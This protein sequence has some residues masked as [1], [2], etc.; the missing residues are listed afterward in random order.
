MLGP[1]VIACFTIEIPH[2][3][4]EGTFP[5]LDY[6]KD[7]ATLTPLIMSGACYAGFL[8]FQ[9]CGLGGTCSNTT[10]ISPH[11]SSSSNSSNSTTLSPASKPP[12]C[13]CLPG[14]SGHSDFVPSDRT[15]W[16][17]AVIECSFNLVALRVLWGVAAVA[18]VVV[19]ISSGKSI[20]VQL[21]AKRARRLQRWV[22][23]FPLVFLAG[24]VLFGV[25]AL[26]FCVIKVAAPQLTIGVSPLTTCL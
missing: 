10:S 5:K 13:S 3:Y 24:A 22:D 25:L 2:T 9:T 1:S 19:L 15:P 14:Y 7:Y 18:M 11:N 8:V 26:A 16:G 23:H 20:K 6:A 12:S 4:Y 17:G 21:A